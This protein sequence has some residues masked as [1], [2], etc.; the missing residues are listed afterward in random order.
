LADAKSTGLDVARSDRRCVRTGVDPVIL[1]PIMITGNDDVI[2]N[3]IRVRSHHRR[4][5]LTRLALDSACAVTD[6]AATVPSANA[7]VIIFM[8]LILAGLR[9][10]NARWP[11]SF[12]NSVD[13][14]RDGCPRERGIDVLS[15]PSSVTAEA[16]YAR[17]GFKAVRNAFH[18]DERTI[19]MACRLGGLIAC[20]EKFGELQQASE[21]RPARV[22]ATTGCNH[23]EQKAK[24]AENGEKLEC[25]GF[26][27]DTG[28]AGKDASDRSNHRDSLWLSSGVDP[29]RFVAEPSEMVHGR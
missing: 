12:Q 24:Q 5:H 29:R 11:W 27:V 8:L 26:S 1:G 9:G 20:D 14:R 25:L 16:F 13:G 7:T 21:E 18:G 15:V 17:L 3:P 28:N 10:K 2:G 4:S 19:I 22:Q 6:S 23:T